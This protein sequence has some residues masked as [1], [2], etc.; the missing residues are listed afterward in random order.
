VCLSRQGRSDRSHF[1]PLLLTVLTGKQR[2][3]LHSGNCASHQGKTNNSRGLP[4][5]RPWAQQGAPPRPTPSL[6]H[7]LGLGRRTSPRPTSTSASEESSPCP[8]PGLGL[9]L[10]L[11]RRTPPRPTSTS[12]SEESPPRPTSGSY[13]LR[14]W[15]SIITLPLASRLRLRRNKTGVPSK[16]PR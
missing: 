2:R 12:A 16:L 14:Y 6:G 15:A 7:S 13:Q 4:R 1:A 5:V 10:G 9:S 3:S 8:T 11:G